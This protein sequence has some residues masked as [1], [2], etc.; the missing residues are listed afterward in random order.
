M[1]KMQLVAYSDDGFSNAVANG[2]YTVMINPESLKWDRSIQYNEQ[3][4]PDSGKASS[5]YK[6]T[7]AEKLSFDLVIDCTGVVDSSRVDLPTE[8]N[9]LK[10]VV[11]DYNGDIHRPN[12][13][14][15]SWGKNTTFEGILDSINTTF[16][17]F[18]PDGTPLRAKVSLSFSS[19]TDVATAAKEENKTSPDLTHL[20]S[21]S[22]GDSLPGISQD[23]YS[24]PE[25]Y[26]QLAKYNDLNKFRALAIGTAITVPPLVNEGNQ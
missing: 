25:Y 16:N 3:Q 5:K 1:I 18:K 14:T 20:I 9:Q 21:V 6:V 12:F 13:V 17:Y 22:A 2:S 10:K 26:V 23:I 19:Y 24:S 11:Y 15:I 7:P 8:L 4:A